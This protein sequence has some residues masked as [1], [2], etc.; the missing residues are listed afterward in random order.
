MNDGDVVGEWAYCFKSTAQKMMSK[1]GEL[2]SH[3][4]A[5]GCMSVFKCSLVD[6]FYT[7]GVLTQLQTQIW[8]RILSKIR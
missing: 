7:V 5:T 2:I 6:T 4:T 3:S 1:N 8:A